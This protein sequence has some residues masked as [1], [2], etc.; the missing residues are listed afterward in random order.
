MAP[1]LLSSTAPPCAQES[2]LP[3][4]AWAGSLGDRPG[5]AVDNPRQVAPD[6]YSQKYGCRAEL[7]VEIEGA[8]RL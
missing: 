4:P 5:R 7:L 8:A 3:P 1:Q 2:E 6:R